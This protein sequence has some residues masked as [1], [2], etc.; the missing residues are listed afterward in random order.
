MTI[1]KRVGFVCSLCVL[2]YGCGGGSSSG[3]GSIT[4][5]L[6]GDWVGTWENDEFGP[7]SQNQGVKN[8]GF[9]R[10]DLQEDS[11]GNVSGTATWT[12]FSCFLSANVTGIVSQGAVS[13]TF[14]SGLTRVTFNG[15]RIGNTN[16]NGEWDNDAGC[17]G[18]GELSLNRQS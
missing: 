17:V 11:Q 2:L 7:G 13:L 14:E 1:V 3:G 12:G 8:E 6:T 16:I 9:I 18:Q 15:R 5:S 10:A 4:T